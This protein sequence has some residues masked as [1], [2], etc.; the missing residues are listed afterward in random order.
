MTTPRLLSACLAAVAAVAA[1]PL[2]AGDSQPLTDEQILKRVTYPTGE[3]TATVFASPPNVSY[4][5]FLSAQPDG[6]LFI[7]CDENGSLD[8][9]PMRGHVIMATDSKHTGKAD[10]FSTFATMDS[11]RGVAWDPSSRTLYVM[12]PPNLTAYHDDKGTGVADRSEDIVTGLG[13]G[14]D[15]RGADHTTNGIRFG[16]DGWIYVAVGDY[17]AVKA[18]GKDGRSIAMRGGGIVRVRPDGSG[19]ER[20]VWGT[21]NI[22]SVSLSPL[23]EI[24]TRDNTNDG[25]DWNDR[26]SHNPF[27][28]QMGY[29]ILFRNFPEEIIPTMI[30][31]G[32]G[33]PVGSIFVDEPQLPK[34]WAYG[35]FSVEWGRNEIDLHPLTPVGATFKADIKQFM[36]MNRATDLEVDGQG[37]FYAASLDGMTFTFNGPNVGYVVKL[38]PKAAKP[39]P[40]PEFKKLS[41]AELVALIASPSAV[42]RQAAQH[43]L[44]VRGPKPGVVE[45]LGKIITG[46][47][48]LAARVAAMFTLAQLTH[49]QAIPLLQA[50]LKSDELREYA[51]RV[52][53]D[54]QRIADKVP[55]E[56]F[57]E[58]LADKNPRVRVQAETGL[59]HLGKLDAAQ[60]LLPLTADADYTVA[61]MA[62]RSLGLLNASQACLLAL[63][64]SDA[65]VHPGALRALQL[66]YEPAVVDGLLKRLTTASGELKQGIF[67]ALCRLNFQ[68]TPYTDPKMWWG[69]RPDTSGPIYKPMPW[70]QSEKIQAALKHELEAAQGDEAKGFVIALMR[71]KL[72]FPG[73]NELMIAKAGKDTASRLDVIQS[74]LSDKA[75]TPDDI[76]NALSGIAT[77]TTEKP[78]M[79][80]RAFRLLAQVLEKHGNKVAETYLAL[81]GSEP[82]QGAL[83]PVWEEFTRDARLAR[84][85][86]LFK[87]WAKDKDPAKRLLGATVLVNIVT[88][89]V[90]SDKKQKNDAERG[91]SA[92][93]DKPEPVQTLLGVIAKVHA[94]YFGDKVRELLSNPDAKVVEAAQ[95]TLVKLGFGKDGKPVG[96]IIADM[97]YDDLVKFVLANKGDPV[98]GQEVF[99]QQSCVVCHTLS[100]KEPPKGPMLAGI[101]QRYKRDELAESILK[102]SAKIAQGFESQWFRMKNTETVEGFVVKEGGDSVEI[103]NIVGVTTIIEKANITERQKRDKSIMP[104]GLVANLPPEDLAA[105]I[106]FLESTKG[107]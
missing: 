104:E 105:L 83:L 9:K 26:L 34:E 100:D 33:S 41:E 53:Y 3:F 55:K 82:P 79:R 87:D 46:K 31:Y 14:L 58:A 93:W 19:L 43:E 13:F 39:A 102:P 23:M 44:W 101:G 99:T 5:I 84:M 10:T 52:L 1:L 106:A 76:L 63:D 72:T 62:W 25:D 49:E 56:A 75:P 80:A 96:R 21:R 28:A 54:D 69:T 30:D 73:L 4:P 92:L 77:S 64:S 7:G 65:K 11:P 88:S 24:L 66:M 6:T 91:I 8:R 86:G 70:E 38:T 40:L 94:T 45:G 48:S 89:T 74:L 37:N 68:E 90:I 29:P 16:I 35:F 71:Q 51:L 103:R 98:R 42:W 32:G 78:E 97:T 85:N 20:V 18:T 67:K 59:W 15:F 57:T 95:R 12:H 17:G 47:D 81:A 50:Q 107:N 22:L 60:Q 36:K 2:Y 27:G 61:H